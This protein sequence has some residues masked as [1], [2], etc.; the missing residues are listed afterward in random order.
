M[1]FLEEISWRGLLHQV[2]HRNE[3]ARHLA[4]PG[5]VGYSGF[6]PT[7]DSLHIGN[8]VPITLLRHFQQA[9]HTPI[10]V[11]G[12]GTGM[13]G[14]PSGRDEERQ[15]LTRDRVQANIDSQ[16]TIFER[17]LDF[18]PSIS[19][20]AIIVNNM[21]WLE[22]LKFLEVL[23]DIGKHFSINEMIQRDSV[24]TRLTQREYGI[25]YTEFSYMLL[26]AYDFLHLRREK[27]CTVQMAGSDQF[28]NIVSGIDLIR[29]AFAAE[30]ASS[31]GVTAPLVSRSDGKKMS[32]SE[33]SAIWMSANTEAR[34]SPY[35]FYQ[36]WINLPDADVIQWAKWYSMI[37]RDEIDSLAQ[38]QADAPHERPGQ[39]ALA[40]HM[41]DLVHGKAERE[42]IEAATAALFTGDVRSLDETMLREVFA[43]VPH[44][45]HSR[46]QLNG[47]GASLIELLP[48]TSLAS[49]KREA[50][51][52]LQNGAVSVN[53]EKA[54][55]DRTLLTKD[56]LHG[57]TILLRRGKKNWHATNWE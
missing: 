10:V 41:T 31:F 22:P 55:A 1:S 6:D 8:L 17:L 5:R 47:D 50:R 39:K 36:F 48:Q 53:G 12:G 56:L 35:A 15:L 19:N 14:D 3:L 29:R 11:M 34:T 51:E 4:T 30:D 45:S 42:G 40:R 26:Q 52:F 57:K 24:K 27:N 23:R 38:Q 9:G 20:R 43:E 18:S 25:S 37:S 7:S 32:K 44:S 54:P 21:D 16:R 49:S 33:G 2:T 28:G 46:N 13:I